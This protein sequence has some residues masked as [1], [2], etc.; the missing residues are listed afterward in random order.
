MLLIWVKELAKWLFYRVCAGSFYL[1][2]GLICL[3]PVWLFRRVGRPFLRGFVRIIIP[4]RRIVRNLSAVFGD[5]YA[6]A[7]KSGFARGVQDQ[8]SENLLDCFLQLKDRQYAE[9]IIAV[10][11]L[12]HLQSALERG[13]GVIALGAHIGNFV[14]LGC[15][16]GLAGYTFHTLFRVPRDRAITHVVSRYLPRY[17]QAVI[18][19]Q[20]RRVAVR[21]ILEALKRN[22]I[23]YIL[24]DN[25]KRGKIDALLFSQRVPSPRG[26]IS[27]A[28]RSGAPLVPMYLV[29]T[30]HG[31]MQL[32][33]EPAIDLVRTKNLA[34]D[35]AANT[36]RFLVHLESLIRRYPDQW[37]W[38]TVRLRRPRITK[39]KCESP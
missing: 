29:R 36:Q 17:H 6:S 24:G 21:R 2:Y 18:P 37:N 15:R 19:S 28:L 32:V 27:L 22:E 3:F 35:I 8:F 12:S 9:S 16:L 1:L 25:L 10:E 4:K 13:K 11:G 39:L 26:P 38:L 14:L 30:Y 20:P 23:V 31:G 5:S 7:T 34:A 33:I